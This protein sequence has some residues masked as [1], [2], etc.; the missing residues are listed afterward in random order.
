MLSFKILNEESFEDFVTEIG[1][2]LSDT[3][4]VREILSSFL[5]LRDEGPE[6]AITEACGCLLARIYDEQYLFVYPIEVSEDADVSGALIKISEYTRREMIPLILS[7]VP[8]EEIDVVSRIFPHIDAR[9]Y[10]D[11]EDCF[12]VWVH[13]ECDMLEAVPSITRGRVSLGEILPNAD[14]ALAYARLCRD[15]E[16]NRYWGYD[17]K[18]DAPYAETEYFVKIADVEFRRGVALTLAVRLGG[19]GGSLIGEAVFFDFDY[20]GSAMLAIR[21]LPEYQGQGYGSEVLS[22]S[23]DIAVTI[24]LKSL[25]ARVKLANIPSIKMT[26]KRMTRHAD[27][28]DEAVFS[29]SLE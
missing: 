11:D 18:E 25:R 3:E 21:L 24:G 27:E 19:E 12:L 10:S 1:G 29:V 13:S 16:V 7:D 14:D 15:E 9:A 28:G 4:Y 23:L 2:M 22:A 5:E 6:I 20:F 26:E 8:R 17:Y